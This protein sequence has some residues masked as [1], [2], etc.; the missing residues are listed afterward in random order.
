MSIHIHI[1][2][3]V[4]KVEVNSCSNIEEASHQVSDAFLRV[5]YNAVKMQGDDDKEL[6]QNLHYQK[7]QHEYDTTRGLW[8]IDRDPKEV[9]LEWIRANAFQLTD[10]VID[11]IDYKYQEANAD[12]LAKRFHRHDQEKDCK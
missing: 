7:L 3:L 1:E 10:E 2:K 4:E 11:D 8:C 5:L 9:D 12:L 6:Q